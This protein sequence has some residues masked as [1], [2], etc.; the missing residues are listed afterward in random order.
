M[1][2]GTSADDQPTPEP[3]GNPRRPALLRRVRDAMVIAACA[4]AAGALGSQLATA[5]WGYIGQ[6]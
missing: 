2:Q 3:S 1:E 6:H 5:A 4:G